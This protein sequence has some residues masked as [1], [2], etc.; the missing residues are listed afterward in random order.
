MIYGE[1]LICA[2]LYQMVSYVG[3]NYPTSYNQVGRYV[4]VYYIHNFIY[5][6]LQ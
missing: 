3:E 1:Y 2:V 4:S 6:H 5:V